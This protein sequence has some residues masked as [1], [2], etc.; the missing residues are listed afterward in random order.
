MGRPRSA[1]G[2]RHLLVVVTSL[3]A[4][5]LGS[6]ATHSGSAAA[7][8]RAG[9]LATSVQATS[10]QAASSAASMRALTSRSTAGPSSSKAVVALHD[11]DQS[12]PAAPTPV[13]VEPAR[14]GL[15]TPL[16]LGQLP[17]PPSAEPG[18]TDRTARRGRGPP[19]TAGT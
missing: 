13:G 17:R 8:S 18:S 14:P 10:V 9:S 3:V 11:T 16:L 2:L 19:A 5:V 12:R 4:L 1:A 15:L 6:V 7:G